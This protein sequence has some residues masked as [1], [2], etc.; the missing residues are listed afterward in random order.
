MRINRIDLHNFRAAKNLSID[1]HPKMNLIVGVNGAGKSTV[2]QAIDF[3]LIALV[4]CIHNSPKN[5][6]V[7]QSSDITM[8]EDFSFIGASAEAN[9]ESYQWK[10]RK[11]RPGVNVPEE[12][13]GSDLERLSKMLKNKLKSESEL[14]IIAFYPVSRV[15]EKIMSPMVYRVAA[16]QD[17]LDIYDNAL[18]GKP[19]YHNFFRWFRDQDDYVNQKS[20]SRSHWIKRNTPNLR[21][22]I[23]QLFDNIEQLM[24]MDERG[25]NIFKEKRKSE[26]DFLLHEPRFLFREMS[27]MIRF[28]GFSKLNSPN[29]AEVLHEF[30]YMLHKMD[31]LSG[32]GRDSIIDSK[33]NLLEILS[34]VLT[35][36]SKIKI[37]QIDDERMLNVVWPMFALSFELGLWWLS[38][39][40]HSRLVRE[41]ANV[42]WSTRQTTFVKLDSDD[43]KNRI[44]ETVD[45]IIEN[46]IRRRSSAQTNLGRDI[47]NVA[48]AIEQFVPEYSNLRI[49]RTERG[50]SQMLVDKNGQE[51]D[52]GQL[53][54]G[55]KNLIALVGD[56]ARRLT[57]GNPNSTDPLK[58]S[59]IVLIDEL[60]LH[61][62]PKWQ[63]L[64]AERITEVF[65]NCQFIV[66]SHSPQV[67]SHIRPESIVVLKNEA[68]EITK[69]FVNDSYGK[70]SDRILED[71]MDETP[72]PKFI[73]DEIKLIFRLIQDGNITEAQ[74]KITKLR[75]DIGEDGDLIKAGVLIKRRE[76]IG[77]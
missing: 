16:N 26:F 10:I 55:E 31:M 70:N 60:E 75:S 49:N 57:I 6:G 35:L 51:F 25:R 67:I 72:R 8:N 28:T 41:L 47:Q 73:D 48:R 39:E 58:K 52:I 7:I 33:G 61:L 14:P 24:S 62:H 66:S 77:K 34:R 59:G 12:N 11:T 18:E 20:L 40:G 38:D 15:V 53:S 23:S 21:R 37:D 74:G 27:E 65:P 71:I 46:D 32:E 29:F 43:L 56:I 63:R 64:V 44:V 68:G 2:L 3:A 4:R 13:D 69:H 30:D 76:I 19:N 50:L 42:S 54:D 1:L 36:I 17:S 5:R 9:E 22:R 45:K